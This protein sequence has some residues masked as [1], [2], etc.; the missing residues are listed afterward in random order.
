MFIT[1]TYESLSQVFSCTKEYDDGVSCLGW[2]CGACHAAK[3]ITECFVCDT[4]LGDRPY[5]RNSLAE[6]MVKK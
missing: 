2:V 5:R 6:L 1:F 4:K 3:K